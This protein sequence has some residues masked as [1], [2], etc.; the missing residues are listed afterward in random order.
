MFGKSATY[1]YIVIIFLFL[2]FIIKACYDSNTIEVTHYTIENSPLGKVLGGLKVVQLSDLHIKQV[3]LREKKVLE[4]L[5][6]EKPDLIL[7]TGD[8]IS[9]RGP[10]EP[11]ISF[12][13]QLRSPFGVYGVL[14]NTDYYNENGSCI[15]C[16]QEKSKT[17]KKEPPFF[18]R[19]TSL[20]LFVKSNSLLLIGVDDPVNMKSDLKSA[21]KE[22]KRAYLSILLSHSPELFEEA[23]KSGVDWV[24][25]GHTHGGQISGVGLLQ[26]ILPLD[27]SFD[28]LKGFFQKGKTLMYVNRGI[29]TSYL[30]F[31]LG[32]KPEIAF[33][34]FSNS[35]NPTNF[36]REMPSLFHRNSTNP[37]NLRNSLFIS[38]HAS[39]TFFT[40][41]SL[42]S[43]LE[44]FNVLSFL[45]SKNPTN[46]INPSNP[47][48]PTNP[49]NPTNSTNSSHSRNFFDFESD[50]DLKKL[51][52]ECHKWFELSP[53]HATSGQNSLKV[54]LPAGKY[55]G[56]NFRDF[57]K[58]WSR[59]ARLKMDIFNPSREKCIFHVRID[60][61]RS[62]WEYADR[63]D[64]NFELKPGMTN[65][66]IPTDSLKTN[67]Q[68]RPLDLKNIKRFIVFVPDNKIKRELYLD[69]LRLE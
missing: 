63:F 24:L 4:I 16:H 41:L 25:S 29:G 2:C 8:Y 38:N 48:N 35:P 55:A 49:S 62:G 40:G 66:S 3:G 57:S 68:P 46:S 22:N 14:G 39:K 1:L 31:R 37:S 23:V 30:P 27:P 33:F 13:S 12:F 67:T 51:N 69:N 65:I 26:R 15:L 58:D 5:K 42:S 20:K 7:L 9:F 53:E 64:R 34:T 60:D 17:L 11:V 59:Y 45:R 19:N 6:T 43:L 50:S 52:W 47:N 36:S 18:L 10:Y 28:R 54:I 56:I 61:R 32:V 44:T 21:I